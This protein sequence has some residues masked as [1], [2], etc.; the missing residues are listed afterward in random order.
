MDEIFK[1]CIVVLILTFVGLSLW[2]CVERVSLRYVL[3][4]DGD[5]ADICLSFIVC[6]PT[7]NCELNPLKLLRD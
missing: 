6:W 7:A 1:C 2:V 4:Y 5:V 3:F